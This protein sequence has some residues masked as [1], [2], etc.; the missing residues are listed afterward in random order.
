MTVAIDGLPLHTPGRKTGE[1]IFAGLPF[2]G[3]LLVGKKSFF[4]NE[5]LEFRNVLDNWAGRQPLT[6]D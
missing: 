3:N 5:L 1:V 6:A 4:T 2:Q